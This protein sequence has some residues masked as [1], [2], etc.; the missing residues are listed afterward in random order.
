MFQK[1]YIF[2]ISP[3]TI[4]PNKTLTYHTKGKKTSATHNTVK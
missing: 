4:I 3:A 1:K 2:S